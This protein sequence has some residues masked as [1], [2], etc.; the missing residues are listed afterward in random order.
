MDDTFVIA[1]T[2]FVAVL[3]SA[4]LVI[5]LWAFQDLLRSYWRCGCF[6][7]YSCCIRDDTF[8]ISA[9]SPSMYHPFTPHG[10]EPGSQTFFKTPTI[11]S[12]PSVA[13]PNPIVGGNNNADQERHHSTFIARTVHNR[14]ESAKHQI[15]RSLRLLCTFVFSIFIIAVLF[16][17]IG[18]YMTN[19]AHYFHNSYYTRIGHDYFLLPSLCIWVYAK[20]PLYLLFVAR[21]YFTFRG[22]IYA[23]PK[24]TYGFLIFMIIFEAFLVC[25]WINYPHLF[26]GDLFL[27]VHSY[28]Y[29]DVDYSSITLAIW[30]VFFTT[31]LLFLFVNRLQ[32]LVVATHEFDERYDYYVP[33]AS[34]KIKYKQQHNVHVNNVNNFNVNQE[35]SNIYSSS[36]SRS[37][38]IIATGVGHCESD[39]VNTNTNII[40]NTNYNKTDNFKIAG[41]DTTSIAATITTM[42]SLSSHG[43]MSGQQ[44]YD[45][46]GH[47]VS[48]I[49]ADIDPVSRGTINYENEQDENI[50]GVPAT[51]MQNSLGSSMRLSQSIASTM[52]SQLQ[53][54]LVNEK[55]NIN[56]INN[57]NNNN[58]DVR[59]QIEQ[60]K[61]EKR[62]NR[63]KRKQKKS[64]RLD[65]KQMKLV[66]TVI[67]YTIL[68]GL[69]MISTC[70]I[71]AIITIRY[72]VNCRKSCDLFQWC[73][74]SLFVGFDITVNC[75]CLLLNTS[76]NKEYYLLLCSRCHYS[77]EKWYVGR[78]SKKIKK[79]ERVSRLHGNCE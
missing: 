16:E 8:M 17:T 9:S 74:Q 77:Y 1:F 47:G 65:E 39:N 4:L 56:Y 75:L 32:A 79:F 51:S 26:F 55:E 66:F 24:Y 59:L 61:R 14:G 70:I 57:N 46:G 67:R 60:E 6:R 34:N 52:S 21:I 10:T 45:A 44:Q 30:D 13:I 2:W 50:G 63:E 7:L 68:C 27:L 58:E 29:T 18:I 72:T 78:T 76:Y 71:M 69:S 40:N 12:V 43:T 25:W 38:D 42:P 23:Y 53:P 3:I 41:A 36:A 64:I 31:F 33:T 11:P 35:K 49:N 19:V 22:S 73:L 28:E 15:R 5:A 20:T 54:K 48:M 37:S 62:D